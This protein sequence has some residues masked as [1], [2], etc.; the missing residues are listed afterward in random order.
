MV[1]DTKGHDA[2]DVFI[3]DSCHIICESFKHSPV[4]RIGGDEFV[5]F[6]KGED[7]ANREKLLNLFDLQMEKNRTTGGIVIAS[8]LEIY[9]SERADSFTTVF[10][11]ADKKM[12]ERKR[13]LKEKS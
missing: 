10:D 8:G 4:Y 11:R 6:L 7:Y 3:K 13:K 1:N 2:G 9:R 12:Y 5:A